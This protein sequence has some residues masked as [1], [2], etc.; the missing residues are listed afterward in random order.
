MKQGASDKNHVRYATDVVAG[1]P[2]AVFLGITVE[3]VR[4]A[5]ARLSLVVKPHYLNAVERA[6]GAAISALVDQSV[7]VA[8][9][10]TPYKALVVELKINFLG[11]AG[12]GDTLTAEARALDL[13]RKLSLWQVEVTRSGGEKVALAQA[14]AYH[15]PRD[16][17]PVSE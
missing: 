13:K 2:M 12:P 11:A 4:E 3:E 10:A 7:A 15:R 6:H 1:D 14:L 5:Y 9:N 8:S 17:R 16:A